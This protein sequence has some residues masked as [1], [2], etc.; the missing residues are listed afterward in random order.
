MG[1]R[2]QHLE[3]YAA[4]A[5]RLQTLKDQDAIEEAMSVRKA[6]QDLAVKLDMQHDAIMAEHAANEALARRQRLLTFRQKY[7]Q[8][9]AH[10][11]ADELSE[12]SA[13]KEELTELAAGASWKTLLAEH[14]A[15]LREE[16]ARVPSMY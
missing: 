16:A 15:L 8:F 12:A 1:E 13:L 10:K 2:Q 14:D 7:D 9:Q 4:A 3:V 6:M 5:V 11:E